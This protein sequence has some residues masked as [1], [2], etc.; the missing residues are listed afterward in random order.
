VRAGI[1][2]STGTRSCWRQRGAERK[3]RMRPEAAR[4][5]TTRANDT[6]RWRSRL[7]RGAVVL[8]VEIDGSVFD[9][10]ERHGG[11][12]ASQ[13][14][15]REAIA[16]AFGKLLRLALAALLRESHR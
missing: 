7:S 3:K 11:L 9:L 4:K 13:A 16:T 12:R 15:D 10:L 8:P 5:R 2:T 14:D 1:G 6:R